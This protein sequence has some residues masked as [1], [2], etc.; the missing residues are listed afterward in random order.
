[1]E[2][3]PAKYSQ[4]QTSEFIE[5][6]QNHFRE[7]GFCYFAVD[8]LDSHSA[9]SHSADSHSAD[10]KLVT[11]SAIETQN[12]ESSRAGEEIE[13]E[14]I[15]F[16]GLMNQTYESHF[17]PCVDIGWRLRRSAWGQGYATEGAL[18]C[19]HFA[20]ESLSLSEVVSVASVSNKASERVMQKIGMTKVGEFDHL[21]LLDFPE[22][23]PC[24]LYQSIFSG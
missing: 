4:S 10:S 9:D 1:M 11:S 16:I 23:N 7:Y 13:P 6:M 17:T 21:L 20:Q 3:F 14:F 8:R 12:S 24:L 19:L 18:A 2:Y 5:R 15:G 22:L